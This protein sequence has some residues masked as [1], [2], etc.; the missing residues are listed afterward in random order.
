MRATW[1]PSDTRPNVGDG[2]SAPVAGMSAP[3]AD[4]HMNG[5]GK[6]RT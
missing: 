4:K 3:V 1:S 2:M 6:A 5:Y